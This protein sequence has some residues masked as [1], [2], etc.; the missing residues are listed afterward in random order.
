MTALVLGGGPAGSLAALLLARGGARVTLVE[1]NR[2]PRDKVCGECLSD[3][4]RQVLRRHGLEAGLVQTGRSIDA[5]VLIGRARSV[6]LRLPRPMLGVSRSTMDAALLAAA[7]TAGVDVRQPARAEAVEVEGDAI[8]VRVRDLISNRVTTERADWVVLADGRGTLSADRPAATGDLGIKAH[9]VRV[10]AD[11]DAVTLYGGFG[12][13]G[14]VA[15]IEGGRWNAAF[16]VPRS[17]VAAARGDIQA[18]WDRLLSESAVMRSHFASAERISEWLASPLPRHAPPARIVGRI[19]SV[20]AAACAIEPV[21][22]EGMGTALR[23]AE[24]AAAAILAGDVDA[25]LVQYSGLWRRRKTFCRLGGV[26]LSHP[27][28]SDAVALAATPVVGRA[29][30]WL[31]G[32]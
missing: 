10:E 15:P 26:L 14:G 16:S 22:G 27:T 4:G 5:A 17:M 21:G 20:G 31:V 28:T 30:M 19:V 24:L 8:T 12:C 25:L 32:K 3:L 11:A 9:F 18:V 29:A 2:F 1:Q 13:Y 23:S 7:A 6:R